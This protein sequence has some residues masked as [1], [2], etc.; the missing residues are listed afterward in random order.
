MHF[1]ASFFFLLFHLTNGV[2]FRGFGKNHSKISAFGCLESVANKKRHVPR[3]KKQILKKFSTLKINFQL[4]K[5][6]F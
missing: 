6:T 3:K 1:T 5:L 4:S 2:T